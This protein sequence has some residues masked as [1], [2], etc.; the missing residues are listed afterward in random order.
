[1][2]FSE[3]GLSENPSVFLWIR[4]E[5]AVQL[6]LPFLP[7]PS[8]Q[9]PPQIVVPFKSTSF[10]RVCNCG[11]KYCIMAFLLMAD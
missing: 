1:M 3:G 10:M 6:L 11:F 2:Y 8:P 5:S 7:W 9:N 4:L